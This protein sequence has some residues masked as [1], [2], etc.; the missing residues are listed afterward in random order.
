MP[1]RIVKENLLSSPA[2]T[3]L[4]F[5]AEVFFRRLMS[6]VDDY[7]LYDARP[8]VLLPALYP[9]QLEKVSVGDIKEWL[10]DCVN[11]GLIRLYQAGQDLYLQIVNFG[12]QIRSAPQYPLPPGVK[13]KRLKRSRAEHEPAQKEEPEQDQIEELPLNDDITVISQC[14]HDDITVISQCNHDDITTGNPEIE[15]TPV[16]G[17]LR[18]PAHARVDSTSINFNVSK[19]LPVIYNQNS[20][21]I[22]QKNH[23]AGERVREHARE[24]ELPLCTAKQ[25]AG[26]APKD[27]DEVE[28]FMRSLIERPQ[29]TDSLHMCASTFFDDLEGR[30]WLDV[31]GIPIRDWRPIARRYARSWAHN[32]HAWSKIRSKPDK[33]R[34]NGDLNYGRNYDF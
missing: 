32:D 24:P 2:I 13:H 29:A 11:V 20:S 16:G 33:P 34:H 7:G 30:G 1:N 14:N 8:L 26:C 4:S 25:P 6:V 5:A 10:E 28:R 19:K 15:I 27:M 12:Q 17:N 21:F 9:R 31:R 23:L 3:A 18:D 22:E